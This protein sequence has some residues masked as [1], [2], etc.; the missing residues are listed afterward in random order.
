M[1]AAP[2]A[3]A[4]AP[5]AEP[6][7]SDEP[8]I[9]DPVRHPRLYEPPAAEDR[10][11][12]A[13]PPNPEDMGYLDREK[14]FAEAHEKYHDPWLAQELDRRW[15]ESQADYH[16]A[17]HPSEYMFSSVELAD[18]Y[19]R[20]FPDVCGGGDPAHNPRPFDGK[21]AQWLAEATQ[22]MF[23]D[24]PPPPI[25]DIIAPPAKYLE[26]TAAPLTAA[27]RDELAPDPA[28]ARARAALVACGLPVM[29]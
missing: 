14:I 2:P 15:Q 23:G 26:P 9:D 11:P 10:H 16:E 3:A 18:A 8:N 17:P 22:E 20:E 1:A 6:A 7:A 5:A 19:Q 13:F 4:P 28:Q 21:P 24:L 29:P 27:E 12:G 25:D